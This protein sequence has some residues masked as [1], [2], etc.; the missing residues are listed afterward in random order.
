MER[1]LWIVDADGRLGPWVFNDAQVM[2]DESVYGPIKSYYDPIFADLVKN[3]KATWS[4]WTKGIAFTYMMCVP[5]FWALCIADSDDT[6]EAFLRMVDTFYDNLPD[7]DGFTLKRPKH[8]W[9]RGTRSVWHE[10]PDGRR[11]ESGIMFSS[12][13]SPNMGRSHTVKMKDYDEEA[14]YSQT[15]AE[16]MY[17]AQEATTTATSW[18]FHGSTCNG[19]RGNFYRIFN[20]LREGRKRGVLMTRFSWQDHRNV[21]QPG[22]VN[23]RPE[24]DTL[25][26]CDVNA[27]GGH[28]EQQVMSTIEEA[29]GHPD[30]KGFLR[31][32]RAHIYS[33]VVR[34]DGDEERGYSLYQQEWAENDRECWLGG[35]RTPFDR[36][37]LR[38][39][40]ADRRAPKTIRVP[41]PGITLSIL[42]DSDPAATY[43][44]GVD[45]AYGVGSGDPHA[46]EVFR[47]TRDYSL[48]H[49]A[50]LYG[51][52][53]VHLFAEQLASLGQS[54]N[55]A[56]LSIE[57]NSTGTG[58]ISILRSK[59]HYPNIWRRKLNAWEK[60]DPIRD[61]QRRPYG[62]LTYNV[63]NGQRA[64]SGITKDDMLTLLVE[65]VNTGRFWSQHGDLINALSG[66]DPMSHKHTSD[67]TIAA[68]I[69][70]ATCKDVKFPPTISNRD[71]LY[72]SQ[73]G[74]P[75]EPVWR[76]V[77]KGEFDRPREFSYFE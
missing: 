6:H 30:L 59:L 32:R 44:I 29:G 7:E 33:A 55:T 14:H 64:A 20:E 61:L 77:M 23:A 9:D 27:P 38:Q 63:H 11:L 58:I 43:V 54:Y 42:Q 49:V 53:D 35:E 45:T 62:W 24:D 17:T 34:S 25:V 5:G 37:V 46:A 15:F 1:Y 8:Y 21:L 13:R 47:V 12:S 39:M 48:T 51:H 75:S 65:F 72:V 2:Y 3:R 71:A 40:D 19:P 18:E 74:Q 66:F 57:R 10:F 69:A 28:T 22:D 56:L 52:C 36:N 31:W 41:T 67:R 26:P 70:V 76:R 4:T 50:E 68:G 60:H 73:P 16:A